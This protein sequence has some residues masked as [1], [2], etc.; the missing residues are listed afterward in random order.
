MTNTLLIQFA[1]WPEKGRV[2]TRLAEAI[3]AEGALQAHI[4]LTR[5]VLDNLAATDLPL[6]LWWDR[7][8]TPPVEARPLMDH[9]RKNPVPQKV[10]QGPDL[11]ER[12]THALA[13]GLANYQ[14]VLIV[15]SDCPSVEADYIA[16]AMDGLNDHDLVLGPAED[17]GYV[18]IG[19][20][21]TAP[22]MLAGVHW[23]TDSALKQTEYALDAVGLTHQRLEPRWD[24]DEVDDWERFLGFK[25]Q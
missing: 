12:M 19:A 25:K 24:V 16:T 23:G 10:Q 6:E 7:S 8:R 21:R 15:G 5:Q 11:G 1:K 13:Q 14:K 9:L 3:G 18:L 22:G 4:R 20:R 2:K 17:G